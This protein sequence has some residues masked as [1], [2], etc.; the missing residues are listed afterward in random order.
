MATM[1]ESQQLSEAM[2]A[3]AVDGRFPD[4]VSALPP[5]SAIELGPAIEAL[6]RAKT[7]L[8]VGISLGCRSVRAV[9]HKSRLPG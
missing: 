6:D 1:T 5:V 8:E 9:A 7:E 4:D 3:F 2:V